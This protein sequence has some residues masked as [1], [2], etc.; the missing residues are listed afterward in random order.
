MTRNYALRG[1]VVLRDAAGHEVT[2]QPEHWASDM[3]WIPGL[4]QW[5]QPRLVD[6]HAAT[7]I[8]RL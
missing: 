6:R 1:D 5:C 8:G 7:E 2:V 3:R 4:D